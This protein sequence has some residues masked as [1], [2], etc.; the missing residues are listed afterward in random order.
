MSTAIRNSTQALPQAQE[1]LLLKLDRWEAAIVDVAVKIVVW[2]MPFFT[3]ILLTLALQAALGL[4]LWAAIVGAAVMELMGLAA[5]HTMMGYFYEWKGEQ[6]AKVN[7]LLTAGCVLGYIASAFTIAL[8]IKL[9][10]EVTVQDVSLSEVGK[11][12]VPPLAVILSMLSA[13]IGSIRASTYKSR[14]LGVGQKQTFRKPTSR[15]SKPVRKRPDL[16]QTNEERMANLEQAN[17]V[18][19]PAQADY[20]LAYQLK[21]VEGL[22]W[23]QVAE[24]LG[25][26][27]STAKRWAGQGRNGVN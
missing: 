14:V 8:L 24:Q 25:R 6:P 9:P 15:A 18:R 3:A 17:E 23:P 19:Q 27:E 20:D 7:F 22:T 11:M 16:R 5:M 26:S 1:P 2:L 13:L 4:A 21:Y 12:L 10:P